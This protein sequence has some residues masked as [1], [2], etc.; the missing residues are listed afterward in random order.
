MEKAS[1]PSMTWAQRT[2]VERLDPRH[3]KHVMNTHNVRELEVNQDW[4]YQGL[5]FKGSNK[6][7]GSAFWIQPELEQTVWIAIPSS[8]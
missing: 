1:W 4:I 5:D 8:E 7:W 3:M 2:G 6:S